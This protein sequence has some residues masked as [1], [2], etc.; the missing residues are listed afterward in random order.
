MTAVQ[1]TLVIDARWMR[2]G[3]GRYILNLLAG[4]GRYRNGFAARALVQRAD[5]EQVKRFCDEVSVVDLPIYTLR[6]QFAVPRAARGADL[7]HVPHYN[8]P[9][10]YGGK[11]LVTIHDL[12]HLSDAAY[13][14]NPK[15][16]AYA[17]PMLHWVAR[18][19]CHIVTVSEYSKSQIVERLGIVPEKVT[20]IHNG[21]GPGF[22]CVDSQAAFQTVAA[23][24]GGDRPYLLYVGNLKPHKNLFT[25]LRAFALLRSRG[26][27]HCRLMIV[28]DDGKWKHALI[29]ECFRLRL[30]GHVSFVPQVSDELLPQLYAAAEVL[31]MPSLIEGFGY[32]VV[33]AMA[34][35]TP[36][37]CSREAALPEVAGDAA[38]FFD[39]KSVEDMALAIERV[40]RSSELRAALRKK[41]LERAKTFSWDE[42]ARRHFRLYSDLLEA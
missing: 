19:A 38:E 20:V 32:P 7:L 1:K 21:V 14:R 42:C 11:L 16:W 40:L 33:E 23:Q 5:A 24:L 27:S 18:K 26:A 15:G 17:R 35:G 41:G 3:I 6:E 25:L 12:I 28:G 8:A 10:F 29:R 36:V 37:V 30:E 39:P 2:S 4:L 31:V 22:S 34:C 9:V 13:R